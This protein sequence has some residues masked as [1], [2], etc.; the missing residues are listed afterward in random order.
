MSTIAKAIPGLA[1]SSTLAV[2]TTATVTRL[3]SARR[4]S[5]KSLFQLSFF[6]TAS[7]PQDDDRLTSMPRLA[8]GYNIPLD[9]IL[10][11][12]DLLD[13]VDV[14]S[15]SLT[16]LVMRTLLM[17]TLYDN[18][19]LNSSSRCRKT[20]LMLSIRP[21]ICACIRRLAVRPNYYLSWPRRDQYLDEDWVSDMIVRIAPTLTSI[22]TFDWDG[23][24]APSD[25]LWDVLRKNCPRLCNIATNIGRDFIPPSSKLFEFSN[26]TSVSLVVRPSLEKRTD[27][28]PRSKNLPNA[29]WEMILNRCPNLTELTIWSLSPSNYILNISPLLASSSAAGSPRFPHL[30]ALTLGS[31][32]YQLDF[33]LGIPCDPSFNAFL[34]DHPSLTYLR[35]LW[36]FKLWIS[37]PVFSTSLPPICLP[38]L[39]TFI[40]VY[41]QLAEIPVEHRKSIWRVDL[42]CEPLYERRIGRVSSV[43]NMMEGLKCLSVWAHLGDDLIS[44]DDGEEEDANEEGEVGGENGSGAFFAKLLGSCKALE[45]LHFMCTTPFGKVRL[46]LPFFTSP[47]YLTQSTLHQKP[48]TQLLTYASQLPS[49]RRFSLTKGH[50]YHSDESML[51]TAVRVVR[52]CPSVKQVAV[53]CVRESCSN[54]LKQEG[55]YDVQQ[56]RDVESKP[57]RKVGEKQG[58]EEGDEPEEVVI[59]GSERGVRVVGGSFEK[60]C[61]YVV[62]LRKRSRKGKG[63]ER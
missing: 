18:V 9:V 1:S 7:A 62:R 35:L 42:T 2:A 17:P 37:P 50:Q 55:T 40:G 12:A 13:P 49:L 52:S 8:N 51:R 31:F 36:N 33:T 11:I 20:L 15:F 14:L 34:S 39:E 47:T 24:E 54:R 6:V 21:D 57:E 44:A 59:L 48:L 58:E 16:S 41:Q 32:E 60:R 53:R 30:T 10:T 19:T 22:D 4:R 56:R 26:L 5:L 28:F 23:L 63:K 61:R 27:L 38:K 43:L 3:K 25:Y 45:D 29:F 46:P